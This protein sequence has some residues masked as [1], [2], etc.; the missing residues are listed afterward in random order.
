M[1]TLDSLPAQQRA[2]LELVLKQ[3]KS[4][5]EISE[6]LG[7]PEDRVGVQARDSLTAL[8]PRSAERVDTDWRDQVADYL[9]GQQAGSAAGAT[10]A[11]IASSESA[12]TWALSVADSLGDLY[13]DGTGPDIPDGGPEPRR[14]R[15]AGTGA[16]IPA[17]P[18]VPKV[19]RP[20]MP[21]D[22]AR[23][24]R[25]RILAALGVTLVIGV[26]A[27]VLGPGFDAPEGIPANS[28]AGSAASGAGEAADVLPTGLLELK[29]E[30]GEEGEGL[31]TFLTQGGQPGLLVQAKLPP[32]EEGEAYEVWLY[33]D[34]D[35][36]VSLGA[37]VTDEEGNYVGTGPLPTDFGD[38]SYIDVSREPINDD[39]LHAG[40]S[41]LRGRIKDA[42]S[43]TGGAG[44]APPPGA[45]T[46][47]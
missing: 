8:A 23:M 11:H 20:R 47:P 26:T 18:R 38:Y 36:A 14:T 32:N 34:Q 6:L 7:I 21:A 31:A 5:A 40:D 4:Y 27:F 22:E 12:R 42:Q 25:R 15:R 13:P 37:Q 17:P 35:D 45:E 24:V 3:S 29:P 43:A 30:P 1:P 2:I 41:V 46:A 10:R 16:S 9:L 44:A 39:P 28:V 33:N 19:P